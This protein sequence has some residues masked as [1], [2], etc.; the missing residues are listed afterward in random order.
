MRE[1]RE[2]GIEAVHALFLRWLGRRRFGRMVR[3]HR[4]DGRMPR[5]GFACAL[6]R[7]GPIAALLAGTVPFALAL[8]AR[9]AGGAAVKGST[10]GR[11]AVRHVGAPMPCIDMEPLV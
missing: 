6:G 9:C 10:I 3:F 5:S 2:A 8:V 11:L 4:A 7:G 1:Q